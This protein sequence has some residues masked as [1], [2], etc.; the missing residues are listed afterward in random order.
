VFAC[1]GRSSD[2]W[3]RERDLFFDLWLLAAGCTPASEQATQWRD[4]PPARL[5]P[6]LWRWLG[7][8]LWP[9][10]TQVKAVYFRSWDSDALIWKQSGKFSLLGRHVMDIEAGISAE[11]G[12]TYLRATGAGKSW[13]MELGGAFQTG[14]EGVPEREWTISVQEK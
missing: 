7:T 5:L 1:Y 10:A 6:G 3:N 12:L 2:E 13:E 8:L 11:R 14:D 9:I 4:A